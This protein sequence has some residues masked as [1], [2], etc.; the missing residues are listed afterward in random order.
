MNESEMLYANY[1][2]IWNIIHIYRKYY[3]G[4]VIVIRVSVNNEIKVVQFWC[5]HNDCADSE[6]SEKIQTLYNAYAPNNKY[7]KVIYRS[8]NGNLLTYT[9]EL[10]R[11]NS[12]IVA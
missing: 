5:D 8:G 6:M 12:G 9:S 11:Q 2:S 3:I 7:R 4:K 10:L 1:I